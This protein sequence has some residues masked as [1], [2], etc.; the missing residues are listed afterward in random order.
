MRNL[1]NYYI[2]NMLLYQMTIIEG[3]GEVIVVNTFVTVE[4]VQYCA[5]LKLKCG[6][7]PAI[8]TNYIISHFIII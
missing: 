7:Y 5:H 1:F 2:L 3:Y 8:H 6:Q 4:D